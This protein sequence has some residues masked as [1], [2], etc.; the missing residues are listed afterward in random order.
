MSNITGFRITFQEAGGSQ[1]KN[2]FSTDL[3]KGTHCG[4]TPCPPSDG[5]GEKRRI[6][7]AK[8]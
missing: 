6:V 8:T 1:L 5:P 7:K 4:R 3:A 2:M